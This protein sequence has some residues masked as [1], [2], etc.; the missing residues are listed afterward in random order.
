VAENPSQGAGDEA[1]FFAVDLPQL[2]TRQ[3]G[4]LLGTRF[5]DD[6]GAFSGGYAYAQRDEGFDLLIPW[7]Q[8]GQTFRQAVTLLHAHCLAHQYDSTLDHAAQDL[9]A[10]PSLASQIDTPIEVDDILKERSV[11]G[12]NRLRSEFYKAFLRHEIKHSFSI[13]GPIALSPLMEALQRRG[14]TSLTLIPCGW[15]AAFPLAAMPLEDGRTVGDT[16]PTSIAPSARSSQPET[17]GEGREV[18]KESQ[19]TSSKQRDGVYALGNPLKDLKWGE[20]EAQTVWNIAESLQL[21][22]GKV[23]VQVDA[24]Y[25]NLSEALEKG[26]V[27]DISTHGVF[28]TADFRKSAI[29][30]AVNLSSK[31]GHLTLGELLSHS[32]DLHGLRL[33][34]LSACQ[35]AVLDL[36]GAVNEVRS[37]ASGVLQSGAQAVLASLWPVDD[38]ATCLLII[39]FAQRWLPNMKS[40][41]PALALAEAQQWLRTVTWGDLRRW[42]AMP[43]AV[44]G[45]RLDL[46]EA[47]ETIQ[48]DARLHNP[49]ERPFES[50]VNWAGFQLTGW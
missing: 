26:L 23:W 33:L 29:R 27:V 42:D 25:T 50:P 28:D 47:R 9:L 37:L 6:I 30:L 41:S 15:L 8:Q 2:A 21:K 11:P 10:A 13:L 12:I 44:S 18:S 43:A 17:D 45:L 32:I 39:D 7:L 16:L 35:T 46:S 20:A 1:G 24:T 49:G 19:R 14:V 4:K 48:R 34:I 40:K 31:K 5:P 38:Y 36:D 22:G 3:I